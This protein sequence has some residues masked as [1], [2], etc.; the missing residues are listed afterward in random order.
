MR[1]PRTKL[2]LGSFSIYE[3]F[4]VLPVVVHRTSTTAGRQIALAEKAGNANT[5]LHRNVEV[6]LCQNMP[7][8]YFL[9]AKDS[10]PNREDR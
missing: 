10:C 7:Q 3:D 6:F 1:T 5:S 9:T 4:T 2:R 8:A